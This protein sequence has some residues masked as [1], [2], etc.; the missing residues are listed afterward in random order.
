ASMS[1]LI[2]RAGPPMSSDAGGRWRVGVGDWCDHRVVRRCGFCESPDNISREHVFA[3]WIGPVVG[4]GKDWH[5]R[6]AFL[7]NGWPSAR[8]AVASSDARPE[9]PY[10]VRIMQ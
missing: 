6:S 2:L 1:P 5:H 8:T 9:N 10:G 4:L 3:T 7:S